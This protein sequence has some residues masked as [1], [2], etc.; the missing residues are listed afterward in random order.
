MAL[1]AFFSISL[2][3][4]TC[5]ILSGHYSTQFAYLFIH[6]PQALPPITHFLSVWSL[7]VLNNDKQSLPRRQV[8]SILPVY[9]IKHSLESAM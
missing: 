1:R 8:S 6:I 9:L 7:F 4:F 2:S 5:F 3:S